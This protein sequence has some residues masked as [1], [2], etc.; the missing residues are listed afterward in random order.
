MLYLKS[1]HRGI[2]RLEDAALVSALLTM[3]FL[4]L[5]QIALR[6]FM[7]S[8]FLWAETFLRI[9]VLWIA[10]LGAMVAT[11]ENNHINID[12]LAR[13]VPSH[14]QRWF[15][16]VTGLF[17]AAIC[18]VAGW[19]A[20]ELVLFEYEDKTI[21]F[22]IVPNWVCQLILPVGFGVMSLRFFVTAARQMFQ[23]PV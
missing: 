8:G 19:Y 5:L 7:G 9:L 16:L 14:M 15:N 11:R 22:G 23:E 3:L 10:M 1:L 2:H 21:A 17:A 4:A 20:I 18:G 12:A 13:F 6:N